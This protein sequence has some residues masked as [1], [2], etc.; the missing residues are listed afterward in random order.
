MGAVSNWE[1]GTG[2]GREQSAYWLLGNPTDKSCQP[3]FFA[4]EHSALISPELIWQR[5]EAAIEGNQT[6]TAMA[7][8]LLLKSTAQKNAANWLQLHQNPE[9]IDDNRFWQER[10]AQTGRLFC[11]TIEKIGKF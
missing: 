2:N 7:T 9:L 11:H 1:A 3:L 4:L 8:S 6:E 10:N 5:F